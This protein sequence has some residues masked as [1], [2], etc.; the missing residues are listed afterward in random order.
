MS[1]EEQRHKRE[2]WAMAFAI[3]QQR[4]LRLIELQS[5]VMKIEEPLTERD[6]QEMNDV[7]A[8]QA[9]IAKGVTETVASAPNDDNLY[10][11]MIA[12]IDRFREETETAIKIVEQMLRRHR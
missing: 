1:D 10:D 2:I 4:M 7:N 3:L 11:Q 9:R 12:S 6:R 8:T 5:N